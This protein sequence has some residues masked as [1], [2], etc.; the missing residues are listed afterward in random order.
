MEKET[1]GLGHPHP[2]AA[3]RSVNGAAAQ[4]RP[5]HPPLPS[6]FLYPSPEEAAQ[7]P[8]REPDTGKPEE[9]ALMNDSLAAALDA[10]LAQGGAVGAVGTCAGFVALPCL[11]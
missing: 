5:A 4:S 8:P 10:L 11:A 7:C 3:G 2:P 1:V 6:A 9:L